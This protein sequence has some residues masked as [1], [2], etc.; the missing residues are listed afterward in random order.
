MGTSTEISN[1]LVTDMPVKR[2]P[3]Y[4]VILSLMVF[5]CVIFQLPG[6]SQDWQNYDGFFGLLRDEGINVFSLSRFEPGF[7]IISLFLTSLIS[8]N[9]AVYGL[10]AA[11]AMFVK[12]WVIDQYSSHRSIFYFVTLFYLARF[13]PL[14]ELT[15]LRVACSTSF[16]LVAFI[17]LWRGNR[18]GGVAACAAA[19]A[20]HLSAIF[21][22]P[23]LFIPFC[24]RRNVILVGVVSFFA[25]Q[26]GFNLLLYY[27]QE[28]LGVVMA[29][30]TVGFGDEP[31][32]PL[33]A[34]LILDWVMLLTGFLLWKRIS[35]SMRHVLFI[36]LIGM[37]MIYSS[38]D[39]PVFAHRVREM[40]SVLWV[41][42]IAE[43]LQHEPPIRDITYMLLMLNVGLYIYLYFYHF[44]LFYR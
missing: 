12:C 35:P 13:A 16:L 2:D 21:I 25:T 38:L 32:N 11:G 36:V 30:Q 20:F 41:V 26:I 31:P 8:S 6:E 23:L 5:L 3:R 28:S 37:A 43:G 27:F 9:L 10:I 22:I 1:A 24:S 4:W 34:G 15:Q 39:F 17:L 42:Y 18:L 19:F 40:F 44:Q 33:S 7:V 14:H 29:Y